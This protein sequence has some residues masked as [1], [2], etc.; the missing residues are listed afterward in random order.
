MYCTLAA[1]AFDDAAASL[2]IAYDKGEHGVARNPREALCHM[3]QAL[4]GDCIVE[5]HDRTRDSWCQEGFVKTSGRSVGTRSARNEQQ[6]VVGEVMTW[7]TIKQDESS[8]RQ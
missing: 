5:D 7:R 4:S 6:L 1:K 2:A 3:E 8:A